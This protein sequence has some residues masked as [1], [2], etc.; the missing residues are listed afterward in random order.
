MKQISLITLAATLLFASTAWSR[1]INLMSLIDTRED[2]VAGTWQLA[3]GT[4]TSDETQQAR[5]QIPYE[6]PSEYDFRITFARLTSDGDVMQVLS[7]S[8]R[9]FYW[10]MGGW[11]NTVFGFGNINDVMANK[12]PTGVMNTACLKNKNRYT[13][14]VSVRRDGVKAYLNNKLISQWKTDYKDFAMGGPWTM[15]DTR[16][17]GL[18]SRSSSTTFYTIELIQVAGK[19]RVVPRSEIRVK[20]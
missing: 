15:P 16:L 5:I 17:L 10:V 14:L 3:N 7:R 8:G 1:T 11:K 18:C 4:L 6:P 2:S 19:G 13:S 12:N 9:S 20:K